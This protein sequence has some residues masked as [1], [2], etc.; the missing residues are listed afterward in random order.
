MSSNLRSQEAPIKSAELDRKSKCIF[1]QEE[2][3]KGEG[4]WEGEAREL[5]RSSLAI[6]PSW[7]VLQASCVWCVCVCVLDNE[8]SLSGFT[9]LPK[10][11]NSIPM[12]VSFS[13][14]AWSDSVFLAQLERAGR[15]VPFHQISLQNARAVVSSQMVILNLFGSN[16]T[17]TGPGPSWIT[18]WW[19][20]IPDGSARLDCLERVSEAWCNVKCNCLSGSAWSSVSTKVIFELRSSF[21]HPSIFS[22]SSVFRK[23]SLNQTVSSLLNFSC[24]LVVWKCGACHL[25]LTNHFFY[26]ICKQANRIPRYSDKISIKILIKNIQCQVASSRLAKDRSERLNI[27]C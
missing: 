21:S 17:Q 9:F 27:I 19:L 5:L 8:A 12:T 7:V 1:T 11:S 10:L 14:A 3:A 2:P 26:C 23:K 20:N 16:G 6:R 24:E 15:S 18:W 25:C 4:D 13:D 22:K